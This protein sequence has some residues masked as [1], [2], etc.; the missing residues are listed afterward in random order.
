MYDTFIEPYK[1]RIQAICD[2]EEAVRKAEQKKLEE[3]WE[4]LKAQSKEDKIR[5][6]NGYREAA[7]QDR[8]KRLIISE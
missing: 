5:E 1:Q 8:L 2:H 7:E 3:E 4:R 6:E